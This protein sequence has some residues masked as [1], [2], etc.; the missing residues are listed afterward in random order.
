VIVEVSS[1]VIV[2]DIVSVTGKG[3]EREMELVASTVTD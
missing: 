1:S 3:R 2:E